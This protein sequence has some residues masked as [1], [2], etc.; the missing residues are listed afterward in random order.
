MRTTRWIILAFLLAAVLPWLPFDDY[1]SLY[2]TRPGGGVPAGEVKAGFGLS[3][4]VHPPAGVEITGNRQ[5]CFAIKFATYARHNRRTLRVDWR[6]EARSQ[7]WAVAASGLGD[8]RYRHFCPEAGFDAT[9][10]FRV[11]VLGV[12]GKPGRSATFWLVDDTRFGSAQAPAG[13]SPEGKSIALQ[14]SVKQHVGPAAIFRIDHGAWVFG[15]LCTIAIGIVALR[16]GLGATEEPPA[17]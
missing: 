17:A 14:G 2:E 13:Q 7:S 8:N 3:Q 5:P 11:G 1:T 4:V 6:Q 16:A 9:Q 10:P 12:D 15:W